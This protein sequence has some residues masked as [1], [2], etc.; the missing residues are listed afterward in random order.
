MDYGRFQQLRRPL[1]DDLERRLRQLAGLSA[2]RWRQGRLSPPPQ[3]GAVGLEEPMSYADLE[4]LA[5]AYR[6]VLHDHALASHRFPGTGAARRL[7]A[8]A[9]EATRRL[10]RQRGRPAGLWH[11]VSRRFPAAFRRQLGMLGFATLVFGGGAAFGLAL[12]AVQ[13]ELGRALLGAPAIQGLA[14]GR[15]WTTSLSVVPPAFTS[16]RIATNNLTVALTA[17]AGGILAGSL[18]LFV[19]VLNGLLLG[20]AVG[21]TLRYSM[22]GELLTFVAAH[23]PLEITLTL[24]A[25]AAGLSIGR[26]LV[27]AGDRP[28][29]EALRQAAADTLLVMGGCLPWF[30]LLGMIEAWI[31][32][33]PAVP[34]A[35]KATLGA[36]IEL[37]F[38]TAALAP[39]GLPEG[40]D[41]GRS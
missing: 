38:L 9:L 39:R 4:D 17:W 33:S 8:L 30:V 34:L 2:R 32:P 1:W 25:A 26:A 21:V 20:G 24:V 12:S 27:A 19:L 14:E 15:L 10:T 41:A 3:P 22:A 28:R 36:C 37:F 35:V 13:P 40:T 7:A 16:S 18:P 29:G 23:G 6:Q 11:F 5:V 31:S